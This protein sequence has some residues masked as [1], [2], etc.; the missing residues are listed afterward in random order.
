MVDTNIIKTVENCAIELSNKKGTFG[1]GDLL[2]ELPGLDPVEIGDSIELL[3]SENKIKSSGSN[4]IYNNGKVGDNMKTKNNFRKENSKEE[5]VLTPEQ[6][7]FR[8]HVCKNKGKIYDAQREEVIL[9]HRGNQILFAGCGEQAFRYKIAVE[10]LSDK[11]PVEFPVMYLDWDDTAL[12][13]EGGV[14]DQL[15]SIIGKPIKT[16]TIQPT[17]RATVGG[18]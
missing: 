11:N 5:V 18:K 8:D 1:I 14:Y 9:I 6:E 2:V 10:G 16:P 7:A 12:Y 13:D 17:I 3:I 4:F 15:E